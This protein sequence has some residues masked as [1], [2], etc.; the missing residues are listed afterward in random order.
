MAGAAFNKITT[1]ATSLTQIVPVGYLDSSAYI[2]NKKTGCKGQ[3]VLQI[4]TPQGKVKT[5]ANGDEMEFYWYH[6]AKSGVWNDDACWKQTKSGVL[7]TITTE[8]DIP[9]AAGQGMW[10][11]VLSGWTETFAFQNAGEAML[12]AGT[13]ALND[14]STA[15]VV[16]VSKDCLLTEV[17]PVGYLESS[18]YIGNKKTGCKGQIVCQFLTPQGKVKTD[19]NG[20]EMEFYWY[21][22]AKSG[23]WNDDACWKQT[24]NGVLTTI[25]K[26]NAP[27]VKM[28]QGLWIA[29]LS[30][31]TETFA[32]EGPGVDDTPAAE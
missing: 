15:V 29:V 9:F 17:K 32:V 31:W 8:N 2:G 27:T 26:E 22:T 19:A 1:K 25:T 4:L 20:D 28:G 11:A 12:D 14:G 7:T 6:T 13:V 23:M 30:G 5:D 21:H 18:A 24:K 16:P 10:I 3:I